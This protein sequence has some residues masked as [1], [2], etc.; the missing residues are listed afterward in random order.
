MWFADRVRRGVVFADIGTDHAKLP[1]YLIKSGKA[2]RAIASDI[3]EGPI[4]RARTYIAMNGLS[5]KIDTYIGDGIAHLDITAPADIAICGMGGETIVNII[6]GAPFVKNPDI[7]IMMQPMTDFTMLR[8]YLA[9]NGFYP[10]AEDIIES[11]GRMY[12]CMIYGYNGE[13]YAIS[14]VEAELGAKCIEARSETFVKYVKRRYNIVKKCLDGKNKAGIDP[15]EEK[16]LLAN[17]EVILNRE[18]L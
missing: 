17:Y 4:A 15:S 8:K 11:D 7:R 12:Q 16:A 9:E 6:A 1:V 3:G 18:A 10:I 5:N 2:T 14:D 13:K